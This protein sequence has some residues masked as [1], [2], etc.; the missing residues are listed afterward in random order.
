VESG[1]PTRTCA[2]SESEEQLV[3]LGRGPRGAEQKALHLLASFGA[4]PV[5][6]INGF[7][8][9]LL[10]SSVLSWA[11]IAAPVAEQLQPRRRMESAH[12]QVHRDHSAQRRRM[13]GQA[14]HIGSTASKPACQQCHDGEG[15]RRRE[16]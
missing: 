11:H 14:E 13:R 1:S 4:W 7:D 2:K 16:G 9:F 15:R 5:E 8:P 12:Q 3:D 10:R 6:L